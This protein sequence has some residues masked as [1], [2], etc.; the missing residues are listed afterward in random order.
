MQRFPTADGPP[1]H[2]GPDP[3]ESRLTT[4]HCHRS[5]SIPN[6]SHKHTAIPRLLRVIPVA[7]SISADDASVSTGQPIGGRMAAGI[8]R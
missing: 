5:D 8:R 1:P 4:C 6:E 7:C 2:S 3:P